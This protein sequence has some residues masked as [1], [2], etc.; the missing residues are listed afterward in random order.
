MI[1]R[2]IRRE[3]RVSEPTSH[4]HRKAITPHMIRKQ[5]N[6]TGQVTF[7][8]DMHQKNDSN[9]SATPVQTTEN[10]RR[11]INT[12][13][14]TPQ[15]TEEAP[16]PH[17]TEASPYFYVSESRFKPAK[18]DPGNPSTT[19]PPP[20]PAEAA[21]A[22]DPAP[23]RRPH[24]EKPSQWHPGTPSAHSESPRARRGPGC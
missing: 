18:S 21:H 24:R 22:P 4:M 7:F 15:Y 3:F 2:Q 6:P 5:Y 14:N 10:T 12:A 1:S 16:A 9:I 19:G 17:G 20:H 23:P 11:T 13:R 8:C